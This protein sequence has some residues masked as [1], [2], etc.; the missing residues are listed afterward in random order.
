MRA[1]FFISGGYE[2]VEQED[3]EFDKANDYENVASNVT[4]FKDGKTGDKEP[5]EPDFDS[6][7]KGRVNSLD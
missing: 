5:A 4:A 3:L 7:F 1:T 6:D 2:E